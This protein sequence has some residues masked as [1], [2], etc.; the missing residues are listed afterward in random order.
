LARGVRIQELESLLKEVL[1]SEASAAIKAARSDVSVSKI[2]VI[3]GI[4]RSEVGRLIAGEGSSREKHDI[5][6][7]VIGLWSQGAGYATANGTPRPL[8]FQGLGSE[9]ALLVASVSKEVS[10]YPVLFEL[11][12]IGAIRYEE[13]MVILQVVEYTPIGDVEHG[14][15]VLSDDI[16]DLA[17]AVEL[18]L[19]SGSD[20]PSLHLRTSY[21]NIDPDKLPDIRRWILEKGA[22][23]HREVRNYISFFDR[24]INQ[25]LPK[26]EE[27]A[28]VTVSLF[29]LG[30][31]V[32]GPKELKAKKRGRKPCGL[33]H[34]EESLQ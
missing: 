6:N 34:T 20:I 28:K 16:E 12:R 5:L 3:T 32:I 15:Q 1:V 33:K 21:D 4:H 9:F 22:V 13:D 8:T 11:E 14:V 10:P 24:D 27:R 18:N 31:Q 2:S 7:R 19:T 26:T 29:S 23:F 17:T 25:A 30:T